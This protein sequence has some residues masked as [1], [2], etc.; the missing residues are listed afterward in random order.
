MN[1]DGPAIER[2]DD[3]SDAALRLLESAYDGVLSSFDAAERSEKEK[4][5]LG[6]IGIIAEK[7]TADGSVVFGKREQLILK[8]KLAKYFQRESNL[9]VSTLVDAIIETPEF[10]ITE[11]G[12]LHRL[13]EVHEQ[14]TLQKIA[15]IR[16]RRAEIGRSLEFNPYQAVFTTDSGKFYLAELLNMPHLEDESEYMR[17]CVGTSDSYVNKI[18]QGKVRIFSLRT[19]PVMNNTLGH[20]EGDKP[21][22]TIEYDPK[23]K[24]ILQIR[25]ANDALIT[26]N[27]LSEFELLEVVRHMDTHMTPS[28][29]TGSHLRVSQEELVNLN[30]PDYYVLTSAGMIHYLEFFRNQ[31]D[32]V[33]KKG[34]MPVEGMPKSDVVKIVEIF[35]GKKFQIGEIA[36]QAADLTDKTKIYIG[37]LYP[38]FFKKIPDSLESVY[39]DWPEGVIELRQVN[40]GMKTVSQ[41]FDELRA[42][43]FTL[44]SLNV[45]FLEQGTTDIP[46]V[47]VGRKARFVYLTPGELGFSKHY[48]AS[49]EGLYS[50]AK[51]FGLRVCTAEEALSFNIALPVAT[52]DPK[53]VYVALEDTKN[54]YKKGADQEILTFCIWKFDNYGSANFS[55]VVPSSVLKNDQHFIF[56]Y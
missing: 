46:S 18:R 53:G 8:L 42:K 32:A 30:V 35:T 52:D 11:R 31:N 43:G 39:T 13:L 25:G 56:A 9:D 3:G 15:E 38:G 21:V 47:S 2:G 49:M 48:P 6:N 23:N 37:K 36:C 34:Y 45:A 51:S 10:V 14:K 24:I 27:V 1:P 54:I 50:R 16:K 40:V 28:N 4:L 26:N 12:S 5:V 7:L 41:M 17:H 20:L 55:S 22:L 29:S 19:A 33:L 44:G